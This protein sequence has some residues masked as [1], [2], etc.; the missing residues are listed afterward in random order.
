MAEHHTFNVLAH[1]NIYTGTAGRELRIEFAIPSSGVLADTGFIILV[2]GFG[3]HIDSNVYRKM[4][5]TFADKYNTVTIQCEYFGSSFMQS[6]HQ[7]NITNLEELRSILSGAEWTSIQ[8]NPSAFAELIA[9]KS[10]HFP[11]L[12][13]LNETLENF[14]DMG[15][16]QAIDILTAFETVKLLLDDNG[17]EYDSNR[18]IGYGHSHGAYLIHLCN[19]ISPDTFSFIVDNSAWLEPVYIDRY[20]LVYKEIGKSLLVIHYDYLAKTATKNKRPSNL[21]DLYRTFRNKAKVVC[22]IGVDDNLVNVEAKKQFIHKIEKSN[23]ITVTAKDVDKIKYKSTA[24]GLD[25]DFIELFS[26]ALTF[27]EGKTIVGDTK[28]KYELQHAHVKIQADF[29]QGL[30]IF[31]FEFGSLVSSPI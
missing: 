21:A 25:A 29:M 8:K 13:D 23:F 26:Y 2:P 7:V 24:H 4:R 30:P 18:V 1:P 10:V 22:F 15:Y 16:M 12:A 31:S 20:R 19:A 17:F 3:A 27:E 11:V 5:D 14:N 28:S 9:S 6:D